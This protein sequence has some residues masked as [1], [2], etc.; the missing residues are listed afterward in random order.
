MKNVV[1][2]GFMGSGKSTVGIRLSYRLRCIVED[3]D[4]LIEKKEGMKIKEM[5]AQKGEPY[6]RA[7]ETECLRR[8]LKQRE[9]KIIATGGGLPMNRE[10][11]PLLKKLGCVVYLKISPEDV[12]NRLK[13]DTTRPLL[14]CEDPYGRICELLKERGPLYEEAAD[15][16]IEVGTKNMEQVLN[17]IVD[18]LA[19]RDEAEGQK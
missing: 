4:K 6:F 1:L 13:K 3:T 9:R 12:W 8:L 18:G 19:K 7:Q 15:M 11:H 14:Q 2:I 10:N 5:F 16:V 17:E